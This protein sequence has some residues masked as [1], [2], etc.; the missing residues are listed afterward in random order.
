MSQWNADYPGCATVNS[1]AS[2]QSYNAKGTT[3][4]FGIPQCSVL[5]PLL[6]KNRDSELQNGTSYTAFEE[7]MGK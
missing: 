3:V 6:D 4:Y 1:A 5:G 2:P 7:K